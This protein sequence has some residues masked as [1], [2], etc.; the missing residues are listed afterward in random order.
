MKKELT[1]IICP[2]GCRISVEFDG[3]TL[4]K[5]EGNTCKRG[6]VYAKDETFNPKRTITSTVKTSDGKTISVKTNKPIDKKLMFECMKEINNVQ[7]ELPI[8]IG[9]IVIKNVLGTDVDIIATQ[10][11]N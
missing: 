7:A 5:I 10:N 2:K 9:D 6:E 11:K 1:C 4:T 3:D 8:C